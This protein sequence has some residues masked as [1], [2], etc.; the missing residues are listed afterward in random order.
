MLS[1]D[2]VGY[3]LNLGQI[4]VGGCEYREPDDPG[5]LQLDWLEVQLRTFRQRGMQVPCTTTLS[6]ICSEPY[7]NQKVWLTGHVP[8]SPGNYFPECV[9]IL[10]NVAN[11][12]PFNLSI[13]DKVCPLCG[14][15]PS[16]PGHDSGTPVRGEL[17]RLVKGRSLMIPAF[18]LI[19]HE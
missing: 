7:F 9:S 11:K 18:C 10:G 14:A 13:C 6:G 17:R 16:V 4:A 19:A 1:T 12:V 8:P 15:V 2:H 3:L 5:N